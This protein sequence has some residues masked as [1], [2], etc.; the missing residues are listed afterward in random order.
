M[1]FRWNGG[2]GA[3]TCEGCDVI[4]D[5]GLSHDEYERDYVEPV[6]C[7]RCKDEVEVLWPDE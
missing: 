3:V 5:E 7:E 2:Y 6:Y 1:A 4:V